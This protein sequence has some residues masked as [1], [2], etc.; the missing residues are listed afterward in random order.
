KAAGIAPEPR[1]VFSADMTEPY[2]Y[3]T[4]MGLLEGANPPTAF[5]TSS[6]IT[7]L[8]VSRAIAHCGLTMGRDVSVITHD[9]ALWFLP[10]QGKVPMF[11]S[12]KSSIRAAGKRMAEMLIDAIEGRAPPNQTELWEAEFVVGTSTGPAPER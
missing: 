10:N 8:G 2:G 5:L 3:H 12:T 4:V 6:L 1:L 11:T 7:A 9:D